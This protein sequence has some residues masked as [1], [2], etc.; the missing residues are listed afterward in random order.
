LTVSH[1]A[2]VRTVSS[3][4]ARNTTY[5]STELLHSVLIILI[6]CL[7]DNNATTIYNNMPGGFGFSVFPAGK[8]ASAKHLYR[9]VHKNTHLYFAITQQ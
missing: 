4:T 1:N 8:V 7:A 6:R 3:F 9:L 5:K 2:L